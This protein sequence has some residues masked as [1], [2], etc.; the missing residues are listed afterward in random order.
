MNCRWSAIVINGDFDFT[1]AVL[2]YNLLRALAA[3]P[4]PATAAS[5]HALSLTAC[6]AMP[7]I[8]R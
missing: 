4:R 1:M 5:P 2:A 3:A 7:P 6:G 8:S